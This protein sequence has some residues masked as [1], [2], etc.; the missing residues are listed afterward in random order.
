MATH[1]VPIPDFF[2]A[3]V[4][5]HHDE[6]SSEET[7]ELRRQTVEFWNQQLETVYNRRASQTTKASHLALTCQFQHLDL[8]VRNAHFGSERVP[9]EDLD[10]R[11]NVYVELT[12]TATFSTKVSSS[13]KGK[14]SRTQSIPTGNQVFRKMIAGDSMDYL[15]RF[16]KQETSRESAKPSK[17]VFATAIEVCAM[18]LEEDPDDHVLEIRSPTFFIALATDPFD[19]DEARAPTAT[20]IRNYQRATHDRIRHHLVEEHPDT[21]V[22]CQLTL[23][24]S[25]TEGVKKPDD[26]FNLYF[27]HDLVAT[28]AADPPSE[29]ELF[30][31]VMRCA[32]Q[33]FSTYVTKLRELEGTPFVAVTLMSIQLTGLEEV[34]EGPK[35]LED[36]P[37]PQ[38]D[39]VEEDSLEEQG[40]GDESEDS[41]EGK[42][43]EK[44]PPQHIP[45]RALAIRRVPVFL[46]L[47]ISVEPPAQFPTPDELKDFE[48]LVLRY[49]YTVLKQKYPKSL[50]DMELKERDKQFGA[51]IPEPRFNLC[52]EYEA[53]LRFDE[54]EMPAPEEKV[55]KKLVLRVNLST[56]LAHVRK[57]HPECFEKCTEVSMRKKPKKEKPEKRKPKD[58][59]AFAFLIFLAIL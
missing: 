23:A 5:P 8:R 45:H 42:P 18:R 25:Q 43:K 55:L 36:V 49:F 10:E 4:L 56:I 37:E 41:K 22:D 17:S 20:E 38:K 12:G 9:R 57:L 11:F 21:L 2:V 39:V 15:C 30:A 33:G 53:T 52:V 40:S 24:K 7:E 1:A 6:P 27:E 3:L 16:V 54:T 50:V 31:L 46:A 14:T 51:G 59:G 35:A 48:H 13:K 19:E 32:N 44:P 28:F 58:S 34:P 29:D 47:A 26:R